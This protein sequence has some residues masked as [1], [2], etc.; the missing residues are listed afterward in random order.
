VEVEIP[1]ALGPALDSAWRVHT[2]VTDFERLYYNW[3]CVPPTLLFEILCREDVPQC[4]RDIVVNCGV[5]DPALDYDSV[6][7]NFYRA[8]VEFLDT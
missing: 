7:E 6:D 8:V 1:H 4:V 3:F 5:R 2:P